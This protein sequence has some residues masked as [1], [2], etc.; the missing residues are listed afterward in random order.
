[1]S[2]KFGIPPD[3]F[4]CLQTYERLDEVFACPVFPIQH[5]KL[6]SLSHVLSGTLI[7]HENWTDEA[8]P[9]SGPLISSLYPSFIEKY[10]YCLS[11]VRT[12][13]PWEN[14]HNYIGIPTNT[15]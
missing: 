1:M 5:S 3:Y 8:T 9:Q 13:I 14:D 6:I 7:Y 10:P 4:S 15:W 11:F 2:C 12:S